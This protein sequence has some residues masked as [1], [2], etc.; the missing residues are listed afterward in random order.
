MK[1]YLTLIFLMTVC[2]FYSC[3]DDDDVNG[4]G[5]GS[6][7]T[8]DIN[9]EN[10]KM[11]VDDPIYDTDMKHLL[12]GL[13]NGNSL[14]DSNIFI[15]FNGSFSPEKEN[16]DFGD[17]SILFIGDKQYAKKSGSAQMTKNDASNQVIEFTYDCIFFNTSSKSDVITVK[18]AVKIKYEIE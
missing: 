2:L 4:G 3:G 16:Y 15:T 9:G 18:G 8:L 13:Y 1:K 14:Y 17:A 10:V 12:F 5:S 6:S 7:L 11:Y